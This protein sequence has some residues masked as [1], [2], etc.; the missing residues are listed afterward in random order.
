MVKTIIYNDTFAHLRSDA[1][2]TTE[3][4]NPMSPWKLRR[5]EQYIQTAKKDDTPY[6]PS[7]TYHLSTPFLEKRRQLIY[8]NERHSIDTS[9]ETLRLLNIIIYNMEQVTT[10]TLSVNGVITL[11]QYLRKQ[12]HKV[13]YVKLDAWIK[14]LFLRSIASLLSS[15]L[16]FV[17]NFEESELPFLYRKC[18]EVREI[19]CKQFEGTRL[20][21]YNNCIKLARYSRIAAANVIWMKLRES[22]NSIEE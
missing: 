22:L 18:P 9:V 13:D 1:F 14:Q 7:T 6:E 3:V 5:M 19:L 8:D 4:Y 12:G 2:G 11:G 17:F 16:L 10:G 20:S 21:T 15:A